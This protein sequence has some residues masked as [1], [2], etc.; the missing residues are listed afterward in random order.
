M[1]CNLQAKPIAAVTSL[2]VSGIANIIQYE[3]WSEVVYKDAVGLPT[4]CVIWTRNWLLVQ[5][6][7]ASS[8]N[9]FSSRT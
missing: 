9:P 7:P 3:G 5:G 6:I 4:V 1:D 8:A 2:S